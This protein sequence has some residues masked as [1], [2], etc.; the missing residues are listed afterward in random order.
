M[1]PDLLELQKINYLSRITNT[2]GAP[3][4]LRSVDQV[5]WYENFPTSATICQ[6]RVGCRVLWASRSLDQIL[7]HHECPWPFS[8]HL[9]IQSSMNGTGSRARRARDN[10]RFQ[11]PLEAGATQEQTL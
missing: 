5:G 3:H 8:R 6:K 1:L 4:P 10:A 7:E 2:F 11:P 9:D